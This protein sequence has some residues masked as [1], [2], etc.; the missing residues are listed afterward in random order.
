MIKKIDHIGIAV[1][2]LEIQKQFYCDVMGLE[3]TGIEEVPDQKVIAA[4]IPVGDVRIELLQ[5][6]AEDSP[7]ARFLEKRGEGIHHIAYLV[8]G[9]EDNLRYME[10]KEIQLIDKQPRPGAGGHL[11]AFLHPK[12]TGG[13]LT[14]LCEHEGE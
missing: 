10:E 11:I 7:I 4:I 2:D 14:E 6:T 9:L 8:T 13:V 5:P 1:R 3:C 12:S